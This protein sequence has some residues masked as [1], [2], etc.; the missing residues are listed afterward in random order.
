[1]F[2]DQVEANLRIF[3]DYYFMAK[4][5]EIQAHRM[6]LGATESV[7]PYDGRCGLCDRKRVYN[8]C[9]RQEGYLT[10]NRQG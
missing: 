7:W 10:D 1:M 8:N 2:D 9:N 3:C 5:S 6:D 4:G